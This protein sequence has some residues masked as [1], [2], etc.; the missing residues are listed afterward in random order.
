MLDH[1]GS[2]GL[3][4]ANPLKP[5]LQRPRSGDRVYGLKARRRSS[6]YDCK[7]REGQPVQRRCRSSR[8]IAVLTETA[9]EPPDQPRPLAAW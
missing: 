8:F 1:R 2:Y 4:R 7:R 9:L 6:V 5:P 3:D